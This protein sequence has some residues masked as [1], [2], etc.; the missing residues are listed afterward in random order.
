MTMHRLTGDLW[1]DITTLAALEHADW[2]QRLTALAAAGVP[3]NAAIVPTIRESWPTLLLPGLRKVWTLGLSEQDPTFM[4]TSIFPID[5]S[6]RAKETHQGIGELGSEMWNQFNELGRVPYD[7]FSPLWP[8]ELVHRR[9]AGGMQ[10]EREL[11]DDLLYPEAPIP[12]SITERAAALGRSAALHRERSAAALFN[13]AFTDTGTDNEGFS[14]SGPD[15]VGL[16]STAH[17]NSPSDATTQSNEFTLAL[18]GDNLTTV[19]LAMNA[20]TDDRGHLAPSNPDTLLIPPALEETAD[21]ILKSQLDPTS[22][23]N[24]INPNVGRYTKVVWPWLTDT[25]AWF[26]IDSA[27]KR[28]HLI[29]LDRILPEF[30]AEG[31][32]DTFIAKYRGYYRFSRGWSH[33]NWIAGS[34]PS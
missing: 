13:N 16:I 17:K 15:G 32:F 29:W 18:S 14:V 2:G 5:S 12:R 34:N 21:I 20:W 10:V 28:Q 4:R 7:G 26:L 1:Q 27:K 19:R 6:Q 23:N 30:A 31:D 25:N 22:A 9:Y 11:V 24:A 8:H 33:W 3:L